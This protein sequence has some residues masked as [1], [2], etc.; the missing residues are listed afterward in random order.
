[1]RIRNAEYKRRK[2]RRRKLALIQ[3]GKWYRGVNVKKDVRE[4]IYE[5]DNNTC[6]LCGKRKKREKLSLDHVIPKYY[7]G[8]ATQQNLRVACKT[9]NSKR[10]HNG[11]Y[12]GQRNCDMY[13]ATTG[14]QLARIIND[15]YSV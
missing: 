15:G 1:M 14:P 9:C 8:S 2:N 13:N 6:W 3:R 11:Y 4:K 7:G 10:H 5:R 12:E